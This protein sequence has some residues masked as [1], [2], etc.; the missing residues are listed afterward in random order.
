MMM[1]IF[2]IKVT[3]K[4]LHFNIVCVTACI[5][6]LRNFTPRNDIQRQRRRSR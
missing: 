6:Q 1:S 4:V 3:N 5:C 2:Q